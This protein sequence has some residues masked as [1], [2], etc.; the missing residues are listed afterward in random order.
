MPLVLQP[1][2]SDS[3]DADASFAADVQVLDAATSA[4]NAI[5]C[6]DRAPASRRADP[7]YRDI[8]THRA[9]EPLYG[10]LLRNLSPATYW[11][12]TPAEPPTGSA[13]PACWTDP[14]P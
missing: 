10:P 7:Y 11:P 13:T 2:G 8:Q 12:T 3:A 14:C 4:Q 9:D 5:L 1:L 6:A